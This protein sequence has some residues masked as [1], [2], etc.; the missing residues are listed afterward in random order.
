MSDA[1]SEH[2]DDDN[3]ERE[4]KGQDQVA[5]IDENPEALGG[6][7]VGHGSAD[8]DG[9]EHHDVVREPEHDL[10]EAFHRAHDRPAFL[11]DGGDGEREEHAERDDLEHVAAHHRVDDAGGEGVDEGF[12]ERFRMGLADGLDDVG[13]RGGE[14]DADAGP[15]EI[16]DGEADEQR[17]GGDDLEVDESFCAHPSDFFQRRRAGDPDHDGGEDQGRD[18]RL[19][20][21]KEDVAQEIHGVPPVGPEVAENATDDETDENLGG[22]GRA[23]PRAG[24][25]GG[26]GRGSHRR[27]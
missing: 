6:D 11:A 5:E 25:K 20:E 9:G 22:E 13:V 10:R 18:D 1:R 7:G 16:D 12:D 4:I 2:E 24:R 23:I 17:G 26:G 27:R 14:S 8:A 15:G 3:D 21:I 19:D